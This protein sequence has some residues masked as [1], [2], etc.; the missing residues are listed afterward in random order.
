MPQSQMVFTMPSEF[1]DEMVD[2]FCGQFGYQASTVDGEGNTVMNPQSAAEFAMQCIA[3]YMKRTT[4][5]RKQNVQVEALRG[6]IDSDINAISIT[7]ET[8]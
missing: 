1:L 8:V 4:S 3:N 6:Q 2:A 5:E 7:A